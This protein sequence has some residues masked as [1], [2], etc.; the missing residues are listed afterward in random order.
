MPIIRSSEFLERYEDVLFDLNTGLVTVV[1]SGALEVAD[2]MLILQARLL[3]LI[4]AMLG[5]TLISKLTN[6]LME[7]ILLLM[8]VTVSSTDLTV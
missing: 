2:L 4:G 6:L 3:H 7:P 5:S 8:T 1:A